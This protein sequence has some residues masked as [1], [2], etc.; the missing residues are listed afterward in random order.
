MRFYIVLI[1]NLSSYFRNLTSIRFIISS[2]GSE[3][4]SGLLSCR[5]LSAFIAKGY[6]LDGRGL[7]L[8]KGS[9]YLFSTESRPPLE[10]HP[11]PYPMDTRRSFPRG[12]PVRA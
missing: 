3:A 6:G 11:A 9:F 8:S 7:I 2:I 4:C 1:V 10:A 12:K 5:D